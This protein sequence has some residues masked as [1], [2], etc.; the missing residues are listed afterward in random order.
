VAAVVNFLIGGLWYSPV[1]F[2]KKWMAY[3]GTTEEEIRKR[4]GATKAYIGAFVSALVMAYVLAHFVNY[5]S[6]QTLTAG[7]QTGF[8]AWLG[9]VATTSI[10]NVFFEHRPFGLFLINTGYNLVCLAVMG[11]ILAAWR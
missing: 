4:G 6:A 2:A 1:L 11:A 10:T 7:I 3:V 8:W 5:S 9:F